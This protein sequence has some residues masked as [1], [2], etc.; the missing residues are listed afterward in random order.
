MSIKLDV[1]KYRRVVEG[2][3]LEIIGGKVSQLVGLVIE[4]FCPGASVGD[5]CDVY[6]QG[7]SPPVMAEVVGFKGDT[8]LLMPLG[9]TRGILQGSRISLRAEKPMVKVGEELKGRVLDGLGEP[10]DGRP[11][12]FLD[13][14]R[15]IYG[16]PVSPLSRRRITHPMPLGIRV[17]DGLLSCGRGQRMGIFA[18]S[19]VGKSVLLGMIARNTS[20]DVNVIALIGERGREVREFV[21]RDL[22]TEGLE[23][24]VV[25]VSTPDDPPLIRVRAAFMATAIAEYFRDQGNHVLLMM[26]SATRVAMAQREV[27][28]AV[29]EPPAT[30]GYTPSVFTLLPTIL[31]RV[32]TADHEG[33]ITGLYTVLVEGDDMNEPVA[34]AMRSI[35]DGHIVLSRELASRN[36]YPA[37][38]VLNSVSRVMMDI[39]SPE[40]MGAANRFREVLATYRE[41]EDLINIGAYVEGS[42]ARID[43]SI[44]RIDRLEQFLKQG[45]NEKVSLPQT[46]EQLRGLFEL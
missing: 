13:N 16:S 10:M 31:E 29:G 18:G 37:V 25:V 3:N 41:A 34:D 11:L 43:N 9:D 7:G 38:D 28:L 36:H 46:V 35:L 15:F 8:I 33:D 6:P 19:G 21:E 4:G 44:A 39:V 17:L 27:G 30:K 26:D 42:N 32:G 2:V 5:L 45:I 24:S 23:R 20:A 22:G 1:E 40:Q 14:E 12:P